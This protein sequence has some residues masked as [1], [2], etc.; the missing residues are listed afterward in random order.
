MPYKFLLPND[1]RI[2]MSLVVNVEEGSEQNIAMGDKR[3]EPVD[4]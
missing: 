4:E 2:A 1:A 3:P